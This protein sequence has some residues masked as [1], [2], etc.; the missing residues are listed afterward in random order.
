M[1]SIPP[2][3]PQ[4][5]TFVTVVGWIF[6]ILGGFAT[7]I[8]ALQNI[9]VAVIFSTSGMKEAMKQARSQ[10]LP[11]FASFMFEHFRL[12]FLSFLVVS[13]CC[14]AGAIGLILRKN[15]G[16]VLFMAVMALGIAW[17]VLGLVMTVVIFASF[18]SFF[19]KSAGQHGMPPDFDLLWSPASASGAPQIEKSSAAVFASCSRSSRRTWGAS[20]RMNSTVYPR[21]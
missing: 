5:S 8:A 4:R 20:N 21:K 12:F 14:L 3:V 9:M 2:A 13:A 6:A 1:K 10:E 11:W 15:W 18:T 19:A 17:N 7:F 16:R